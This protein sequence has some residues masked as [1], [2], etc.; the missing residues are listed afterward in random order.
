MNFL[1]TQIP[2]FVYRRRNQAFSIL[3]ISLYA[4]M[5]IVLLRPYNCEYTLRSGFI[6]RLASG[7]ADD[8]FYIMSAALVVVGAGIMALSRYIMVNY[9]RRHELR[10][11]DY[12]LWN[13]FEIF[14]LT[15]IYT[16]FAALIKTYDSLIITFRNTFFQTLGIMIVPY[17]LCWLFMVIG[18]KARQLKELRDKIQNDDIP[19]PKGS[20]IMFHDDRGEM[21]LSVK[22]ENLLLVESADNY[23]C[24]WYINN[25]KVHKSMIR[26]SMRRICE[27]MEGDGLQRCHRSY[28]VNFDH[29]KIIRRNKE[30]TFIELGE[31][32]VPNI[33]ISKTYADSITAWL[34][35]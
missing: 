21:R 7:S 22:R 4:F 3:T 13:I 33:P 26:T 6:A 25:E 19:A 10:N 2:R 17:V 16:A 34:T 32:G 27:Q 20:Y 8:A 35:K 15:V 31:E 1:D 12:I 28:M 24:V 30:G 11:L 5:L 29:V 18:E 14:C 23:I 9:T